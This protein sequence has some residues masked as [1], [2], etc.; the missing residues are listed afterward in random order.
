M[1][2]DWRETIVVV[3]PAVRC[4]NRVMS[5]NVGLYSGPVLSAF[6]TPVRTDQDPMPMVWVSYQAW[7]VRDSPGPGWTEGLPDT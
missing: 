6:T 3:L 7:W 4:L 2:H 5:W 1:T